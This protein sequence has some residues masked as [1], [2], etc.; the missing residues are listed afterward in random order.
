MIHFYV[1]IW[2][3]W[4]ERKGA[5]TKWNKQFQ[6]TDFR[7]SETNHEMHLRSDT[8]SVIS[9]LYKQREQGGGTGGLAESTKG[10]PKQRERTLL[11]IARRF[12]FFS[13]QFT[14][15]GPVFFF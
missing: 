2:N 5:K 6:M 1:S 14:Y 8:A 9:I 11:S 7:R 4:N 15:F 13:F 3:K 10:A 12:H